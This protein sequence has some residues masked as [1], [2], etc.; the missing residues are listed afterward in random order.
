MV[1]SVG[2][3]SGTSLADALKKAAEAAA[4]KAAEKA[5][6]D[7][8]AERAF[9]ARGVVPTA[10]PVD[11]HETAAPS[12]PFAG[13]ASA[14]VT[15]ADAGSP[16]FRVDDG[17]ALV[18]DPLPPAPAPSPVR[19][20]WY[21]DPSFNGSATPSPGV[22]TIT[23][24]NDA[25]LLAQDLGGTKGD[26]AAFV[27]AYMALDETSRG[28]LMSL[29]DGGTLLKK[30][31]QGHT[32]VQNLGQ[33]TAMS[34]PAGAPYDG[35]DILAQTVSHLDDPNTI[36][37]S[38]KNTCGA[39]TVQYLLAKDQPA[40]YARLVI[41]LA[42]PSGE[43]QLQ[44][45]QTMVRV[46][47]SIDRS[48][49][50]WMPDKPGQG[51]DDVERI[52]QAA[53]QD[54]GFDIRG[55]YSNKTDRFAAPVGGPLETASGPLVGNMLSSALGA[56]QGI[57]EDKVANL[58][59]D[60]LGQKAQVVGDWGSFLAPL[61]YRENVMQLV[62]DAVRSGKQVPVD[63]VL[64]DPGQANADGSNPTELPQ[65]GGSHPEVV[66]D[67]SQMSYGDLMRSHQVLVTGI[68]AD[69]TV[70][71]R[72]PWGFEATMTRAE[73]QSRLTDA[74]VPD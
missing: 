45:G 35:D 72:N 57:G 58:Y 53:F 12:T 11:T 68:D 47:D 10:S 27:R 49:G 34:V 74:V 52:L 6:A 65:S 20:D 22:Q 8:D 29:I 40:E 55:S 64:R 73:F 63:L 2:G 19:D 13:A 54:H 7:E 44:S 15:G 32:L 60:V 61:R 25:R 3:S 69:G 36:N 17:G 62:E 48:D 37:Q 39:A 66:I 9:S 21:N 42:G 70:H 51:R 59:R 46:P 18:A 38:T 16:T 30:D 28:Q 71:Y 23:D 56:D 5:A 4:R 14:V 31:S 50:T 1:D 43:V 67:Q 24:R 41:G 33:M 26:Q